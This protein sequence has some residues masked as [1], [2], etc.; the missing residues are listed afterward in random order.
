MQ[1][2]LD[3]VEFCLESLL[4]YSDEKLERL[5]TTEFQRIC[6]EN[7]KLINTEA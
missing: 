4:S 7:T 3:D 1:H 2:Y 6:D 5:R